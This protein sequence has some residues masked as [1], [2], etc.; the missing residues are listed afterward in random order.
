MA[1]AAILEIQ[2][3]AKRASAIVAG[4]TGVVS[5]RKV[6]PRSR[7]ADLS[8]LRQSGRVVVTLSTSESLARAVLRV[9]E[10]ESKGGRVS[11]SSGVRL[12]IVADV[13]PGDVTSL[14]LRVRA[15]T[16]VAL[17]VRRKSGRDH[18]R[19]AAPQ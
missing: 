14:R 15:V 8:S 2:I 16:F 9:A 17:A 19:H 10:S 18:Q 4:R 3:A 7:R 12:L 11:R 13:A 1:T 5:R 6:F